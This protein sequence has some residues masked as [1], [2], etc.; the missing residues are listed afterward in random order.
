LSEKK[1]ENNLNKTD[2]YREIIIKLMFLIIGLASIELC[3]S[4]LYS[5]RQLESIFG[6]NWA[7]VFLMSGLVI[8]LSLIKF[9]RFHNYIYF[10][11]IFLVSSL[12]I[13]IPTIII[14][15]LLGTPGKFMAYLYYTSIYYSIITLSGSFMAISFE[16]F[17]V[18][19]NK[20][21]D[22]LKKIFGIDSKPSEESLQNMIDYIKGA[23]YIVE[24]RTY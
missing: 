22:Y 13:L 15:Y 11:K 6:L 20:I 24:K 1:I 18:L 3:G 10:K 17:T 4:Y 14:Y 19:K 9:R 16:I 23:G 12:L 8:L 2:L 5:K 7:L 21:N